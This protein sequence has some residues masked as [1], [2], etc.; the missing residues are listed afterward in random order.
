MSTAVDVN[1]LGRGPAIVGVLWAFTT[2]AVLA[3]ALRLYLR[4]RIL[5]SVGWDDGFMVAAVVSLYS[6]LSDRSKPTLHLP[7]QTFVVNSVDP[8]IQ[9]LQVANQCLVTV[10]YTYGLGK[11]QDALTQEEL[12]SILKW[13]WIASAP[14]QMVSILARISICILLVRLFSVHKW[15]K[16]FIILFTA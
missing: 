2:I 16:W 12:F 10:C 8:L 3:V 13:T 4:S 1:D 7:R 11:H 5:H 15:F 6:K 14:G 9:I